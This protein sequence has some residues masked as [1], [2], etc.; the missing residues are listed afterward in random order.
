[1]ARL[2]LQYDDLKTDKPRTA[3]LNR[4]CKALCIGRYTTLGNL[5]PLQYKSWALICPMNFENPDMPHGE[6][7]HLAVDNST[8]FIIKSMKHRDTIKDASG[9]VGHMIIPELCHLII[10][11]VSTSCASARQNPSGNNT[12]RQTIC[13]M[14]EMQSAS[15]KSTGTATQYT[16]ALYQYAAQ[17]LRK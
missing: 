11:K 3:S 16:T 1:M 4:L 13:L 15:A 17:L 9:K 10:K 12:P 5:P 14:Q 2:D 7:S 6:P 8:K